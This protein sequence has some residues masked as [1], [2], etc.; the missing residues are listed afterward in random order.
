MDELIE[1]K[2][3][4]KL[5]TKKIKFAIKRT[6]I[7]ILCATLVWTSIPNIKYSVERIQADNSQYITNVLEDNS[8][9]KEQQIAQ[10]YKKA[11]ME[12][13]NIPDDIKEALIDSFTSEVINHAGVFFTEDTIK[14]MYA[15][16][17]TEK[18]SPTSEFAKEHGWWSGDYNSYKNEITVNLDG[19]EYDKSLLAHEQL[20]AIL[21]KG[22]WGTGLTT[23][24]EGYG[25]NEGATTF[26]GKSDN[27][28]YSEKNIINSLGLIL[29]YKNLLETY[30]SSDLSG[31][32][33][34]LYQYVPP[35]E[36][37]ELIHK[38]DLNVFQRIF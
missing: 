31:L 29:E 35:Q 30:T 7:G 14:N 28:Y 11:L 19:S 3:V 24:I 25:I 33:K 8:L 2:D 16:A 17:K 1:E 12:N 38:I 20:H 32:K 34:M 5:K 18:V 9:S 10:I 15:V 4:S 23:G 22:L 27:C 13:K 36:A 21:K 6:L 26:F 37:N